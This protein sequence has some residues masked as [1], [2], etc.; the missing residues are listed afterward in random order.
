VSVYGTDAYM[1]E[2]SG[3]SYRVWNRGAV[4]TG[5]GAM[6]LATGLHLS[7]LRS[8]P[9]TR[10]FAHAGTPTVLPLPPSNLTDGRNH[11]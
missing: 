6:A 3:F 1:L 10:A 11:F 5:A 7:E 2:F 8:P 4:R 9:R